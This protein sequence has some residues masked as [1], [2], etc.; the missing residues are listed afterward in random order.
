MPP[1][2]IAASALIL[3]AWALEA[4]DAV[5]AAL[6]EDIGAVWF[7]GAGGAYEGIVAGAGRVENTLGRLARYSQHFLDAKRSADGPFEIASNVQTYA[8]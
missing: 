3:S 4:P 6:L 1:S 7:A 2:L 5:K 8:S